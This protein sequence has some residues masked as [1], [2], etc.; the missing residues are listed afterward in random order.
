MRP[1][2]SL[3]HSNIQRVHK[4]GAEKALPTRGCVGCL[5]VSSCVVE[6]GLDAADE[7]WV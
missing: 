7:R 2:L 3:A 6:L 1:S 5:L 4:R